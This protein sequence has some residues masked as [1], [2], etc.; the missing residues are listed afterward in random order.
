MKTKLFSLVLCL[1]CLSCTNDDSKNPQ[2]QDPIEQ[3][4]RPIISSLSKDLVIEGESLT[5]EGENFI[6]DDFDT[7][8]MINNMTFDV[9]PISN[10]KI[11]ID[12]TDSMGIENSSIRVKVSEKLSEAKYFFIVPK[13]W[14][15]I[16][17][18][19]DIRKAFV[20]DDSNT[21]TFLHDRE[22]SPLSYN[23]RVKK[24]SGDHS[25]YK[26]IL[27]NLGGGNIYDLEMLNE[28][29]GVAV[30]PVTGFFTTDGF[31]T[32]K[33][34]GDF[35]EEGEMPVETEIK[36]VDANSSLIVNCCTAHIYTSD[37][38]E[39]YSS[40]NVAE[41]VFS[42]DSF[43]TRAYGIG[44]DNYFY[45][46][47]LD[48]SSSPYAYY[49]IKS[50][51][52]YENWEL[53]SY[54][55]EGKYSGKTYFLDHDLIFNI[56]PNDELRI[57]TDLTNS[58]SIVKENVQNFFIKDRFNWFIISDNNLYGTNDSGANWNL[59]LE[60]PID[61]QLNHMFFT[62]NKT[63]LSGNKMLYIKHQ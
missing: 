8:V 51:N 59:E 18:D 34:F 33:S 12:I 43:R 11:T 49:V 44:S 55:I 22:L 54:S 1:L 20:F 57:S 3:I 7:Q 24:M 50:A 60:L 9:K 28:N 10:T 19:L 63:I 5:I 17:T 36:Y 21:I 13:G 41:E 29:I 38:G 16:E 15:K 56:S 61:S 52:G 30:N 2:E 39:T 46:I 53:V 35:W 23:G 62:S 45:E 58:W 14:Y 47:G 4:A 40:F 31:E 37:R 48:I 6:N 32:T 42:S 26:V 25:G 27:T